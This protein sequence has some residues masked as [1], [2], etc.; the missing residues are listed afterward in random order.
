M[1]MPPGVRR[2]LF[3]QMQLLLLS[4]GASHACT[5]IA[6]KYLHVSAGAKDGYGT[7]QEIRD[8]VKA[9]AG[10]ADDDS[11]QGAASLVQWM[12]HKESGGIQVVH[13]F[14]LQAVT[15]HQQG[16]Y[17]ATV[18]PGGNTQVMGSSTPNPTCQSSLPSCIACSI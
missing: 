3:P 18:A 16:D 11:S 1:F 6:E 5:V 7:F 4:E 2:G 13:K 15:W 17:F 8:A 9:A 10:A 12:L 14:P